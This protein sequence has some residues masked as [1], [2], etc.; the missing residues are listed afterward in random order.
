ML[1]IFQTR[2]IEAAKAYYSSGLR[3]TGDYYAEEGRGVWRG[4]GAEMLGLSGEVDS[5]D[6]HALCENRRPDAGGKLNPREDL[7]RRVGYDITF[8]APKSV[9]LLIEVLGDERILPIFQAAVRETMQRIE[10]E[11]CVRVRRGGE[12]S[13]RQTGNLV[14]G[15]FLHHT[16]RPVDGVSDPSTHCHCYCFNTSFD[17]VEGRSKAAEF[18][19]IKRDA[20]Y[21][22]K[23]FHSLLAMG[24]KNLGYGIEVKR[25]GFEVMGLGEENLKRFSRRGEEI[26]KMAELMGIAGDSRAKD[27]L[28]SLT[29]NKKQ[30]S[31]SGDD[32]RREWLDRIDRSEL[33]YHR[34]RGQGTG[35]D[36]DAA[37]RVA[38]DASLERQSVVRERRMIASALHYSLGAASVEA[39]QTVF[40]GRGDLVSREVGGERFV[41]T[42]E[43][44]AEE[45]SILK[46]LTASR[47]QWSAIA[48]KPA[49]GLFVGL[50]ADQRD[51]GRAILEGRDQVIVIEGRAG[52]G[53]TSLMKAAIAAIEGAGKAVFTFAPTSQ[54]TH[55]VLRQEGFLQSETVQQLL[56]NTSLQEQITDS[57]LW[58]DEAGLLSV[59]EMKRLFEI[60]RERNARVILSGDR[61]QHHSVERGDGLRLVAGS[62]LVEVKRTRTVYRQRKERYRE[63]V[64]AISAG[65]LV[66]GVGILENMGVIRECLSFEEQIELVA[67]DYMDSLERGKS[68]LVISPTHFEGRMLT[69]EI[70]ERLQAAGRLKES[71]LFLPV[72][73][74]RNLSQAE[75]GFAAYFTPGDIVVFHQN[76]KGGFRKG[77]AFEVRAVEEGRV[78]VAAKVDASCR[79]LNLKD[80]RHFEVFRQ[81]EIAVGIG[82]KLRC[83]RNLTVNGK[84]LHNGS[85]HEVS[86]F[87]NGK[88]ILDGGHEV[89]VDSGWFDYGYVSTSHASQGKTTQKAIISQSCGSLGAASLEQFYVSVSRGRDE[90]SIWTDGKAELLE[91]VARSDHRMLA[92]EFVGFESRGLRQTDEELEIESVES[93]EIVG[94][95][96]G[97][98]E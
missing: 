74:N 38:I 9:S 15:E 19:T 89:P 58:V 45:H 81:D 82:E 51:A 72:N 47:G 94:A 3:E 63:A 26:D 68:A 92:A 44:I 78:M 14:I 29:R 97:G 36:S 34:Y 40:N 49:E 20:V 4:K 11:V 24:L 42:K 56:V 52:T 37:L 28:A 83:L 16:S 53:K 85:V 13:R 95:I 65:R 6:F 50:D 84:R 5:E 75:K 96:E 39:I 80:C 21:Y 31:L 66:E 60:A 33:C 7:D 18:F 35:L 79:P 91:A 41:T 8:S 62:D 86:A 71:L 59:R 70:R 69:A 30:G 61:Q 55:E 43:V 23:I 98:R 10:E 73:R 67:A 22:E 77:Q 88:L 25:L 48:C 32:L 27:R 12:V 90:I 2:S 64:S 87:R 46:F 76:A 54:A 57:V 93:M 17:E 1:R